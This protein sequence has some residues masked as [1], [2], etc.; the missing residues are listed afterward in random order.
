MLALCQPPP[1]CHPPART[2]GLFCA[3]RNHF[4]KLEMGGPA[5][6]RGWAVGGC[7]GGGMVGGVAAH[8][9]AAAGGGCGRA[10]F[11]QG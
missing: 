6:G 7:A 9:A 2:R 1:C 8:R 5:R 11:G 3:W 4:W 10:G